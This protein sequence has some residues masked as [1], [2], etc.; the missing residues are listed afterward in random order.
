[1]SLWRTTG[2]DCACCRSRECQIVRWCGDALGWNC[3]QC[4]EH[5]LNGK[6]WRAWKVHQAAHQEERQRHERRR[7]D[8]RWYL[9]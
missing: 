8:E 7:E 6:L 9:R 3:W 4:V 1:V 2:F 5:P